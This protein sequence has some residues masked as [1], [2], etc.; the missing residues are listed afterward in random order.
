MLRSHQYFYV[1]LAALLLLTSCQNQTPQTSD[2]AAE[3]EIVEEVTSEEVAAVCI[4]DGT[5]LRS[6]PKVKGR[7]LSGISLGEQVTWMGIART[8][9]STSR[10]VEYLKI[11]LSDGTEGWASSSGIIRDASAGAVVQKT[12]V[13]LRPDL[14]TVT[15]KYFEPMEMVAISKE[16]EGWLEVVGSQRKKKGWIRNDGGVS[17]E[18]AD[19]AVAI[20]ASKAFEISNDSERRNKLK[21]LIENPQ[22]ENSVFISA[23]R[24]MLSPEPTLRELEMEDIGNG[25]ST[26]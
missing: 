25:E 1:L 19:V 17:V 20:L 15:E 9:T 5:S 24:T 3:E 12:Y 10:K 16:Q 26:Y 23:L 8:D 14:L 4:W 13:Y 11:R 22:F 21:S 18:K 2:Q 7:Y 6:I